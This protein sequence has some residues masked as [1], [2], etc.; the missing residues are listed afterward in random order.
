MGSRDAVLAPRSRCL[1]DRRCPRLW[2]GPR[3]P[4]SALLRRPARMIGAAGLGGTLRGPWAPVAHAPQRSVGSPAPE[5]GVSGR[6][7]REAAGQQAPGLRARRRGSAF[8]RTVGPASGPSRWCPPSRRA[9]RPPTGTTKPPSPPWAR[10]EPVARLAHRRPL[11]TRRARRRPGPGKRSASV[12]CRAACQIGLVFGRRAA[13]VQPMPTLRRPPRRS[14]AAGERHPP[15]V[16]RTRPAAA[17]WE[18]PSLVRGRPAASSAAARARRQRSGTQGCCRCRATR[19]ASAFPGM[20]EGPAAVDGLSRFAHTAVHSLI[21]GHV[22]NLARSPPPAA[23]GALRA[24]AGHAAGFGGR[25]AAAS[26]RPP[27]APTGVSR[28]GRRGRCPRAAA[29]AASARRR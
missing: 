3:A 20:A 1:D 10:R 9:L 4:A 18:V 27:A 7:R 28:A 15:V 6:P 16:A 12:R 21:P 14:S 26:A 11:A 8:G 22:E 2:A 29:R 24:A 17:F 13:R 19:D 5:L 23:S 25:C